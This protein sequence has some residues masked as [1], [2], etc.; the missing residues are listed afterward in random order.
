MFFNDFV[1]S[2]DANYKNY[3]ITYGYKLWQVEY[4]T[5]CKTTNPVPNIDNTQFP[6]A[7]IK[8]KHS[9]YF[10][11]DFIN[12]NQYTLLFTLFVFKWIWLIF[13]F[14]GG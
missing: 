14:R 2:I 7:M 9:F 8:G 6:T 13:T 11:K 4:A 1:T 12:L 3:D 10:P 5:I